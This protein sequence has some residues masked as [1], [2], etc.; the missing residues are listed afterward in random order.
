MV[1]PPFGTD[2]AHIPRVFFLTKYRPKNKKTIPPPSRSGI[3]AK[4][5]AVYRYTPTTARRLQ[6]SIPQCIMQ[7]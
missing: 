6:C 1:S 7:Q 4:K 2:T 5:T 3:V